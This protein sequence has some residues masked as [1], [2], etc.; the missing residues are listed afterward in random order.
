M[1]SML[2]K[3]STIRRCDE[4]EFLVEP[5]M[6][7]TALITV[8]DH[9]SFGKDKPIGECQIDVCPSPPPLSHSYSTH[10]LSLR[11]SGNSSPSPPCPTTCGYPS[12][13]VRA[14]Y[15]CA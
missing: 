1:D 7:G 14:Q 9:K 2:I 15:A 6:S 10:P 8:M 3:L 13:K 11:S 5:S 12:A 4:L